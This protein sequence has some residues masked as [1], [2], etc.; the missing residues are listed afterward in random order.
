MKVRKTILSLFVVLG[1]AGLVCAGLNDYAVGTF[2]DTGTSEAMAFTNPNGN[3]YVVDETMYVTCSTNVNMS[4]Y[5]PSLRTSADSAVAGTTN[6]LIHTDSSN[7]LDGVTLAAA[8]SILIYNGTSGWQLAGL[9]ALVQANTTTNWTQWSLDTSIT[10]SADDLVYFVDTTDI[11]TFPCLSGTAQ[12][13]HKYVFSGKRN[14]P[15]HIA[16]PASGGA[17]VLGGMYRIVR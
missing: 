16:V 8:D 11:V 1:L 12:T 4:I 7:T 6:I 3:G 17:M 10:C 13:D 15:V 9:G 14:M 5:K 2:Q